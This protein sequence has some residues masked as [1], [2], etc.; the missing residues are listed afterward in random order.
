MADACELCDQGYY[1]PRTGTTA[2]TRVLCPAG[3]YCELGSS[4]P[5][6]CP[7]GTYNDEAL[8]TSVPENSCFSRQSVDTTV[9]IGGAGVGG[10][11]N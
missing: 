6:E 1:C 9:G 7:A 4:Y 5:T 10:D 11:A 8:H 3:F 2:L